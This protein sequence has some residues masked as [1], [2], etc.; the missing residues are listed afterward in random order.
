LRM[1]S[2]ATAPSDPLAVDEGSPSV[3][4]H[5]YLREAIDARWA[6]RAVAVGEALPTEAME[7]VE[8]TARIEFASGARVTLRAPVRFTVNASNGIELSRG[9]IAG[10][11]PPQ[12]RGLA[13]STPTAE[14]VDLGTEF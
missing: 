10:Y 6:Q 14:V 12:A 2:P 9:A 8:G 11:C 4:A 3:V 7:L 5:A 13:V 1:Y